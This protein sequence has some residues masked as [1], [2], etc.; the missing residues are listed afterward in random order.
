MA[1]E[2][3][4][5]VEAELRA[6]VQQQL[7]RHVGTALAAVC[8]AEVAVLCANMLQVPRERVQAATRTGG[9]D[10]V[11]HAPVAV[12]RRL[13]A[14]GNQREGNLGAAVHVSELAVDHVDG[15]DGQSEPA[16]V[17]KRRKVEHNMALRLAKTS[18]FG[19]IHERWY[20]TE[21]DFA[22]AIVQVRAPCFR[23]LVVV[24]DVCHAPRRSD[25]RNQPAPCG[26]TAQALPSEVYALAADVRVVDGGVIC[27]TTRMH[28]E[29]SASHRA[30]RW[31]T[32][33]KT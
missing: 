27:F 10:L 4:A 30:V 5:G 26:R 7:Q 24:R 6:S 33:A 11:C 2:A 14:E 32:T 8:P 25:L 3:A 16:P 20:A 22:E 15:G 23:L 29:V 9:G 1:A 19:L 31:S 28:M 13:R 17:A 18:E 21:T 12:Y